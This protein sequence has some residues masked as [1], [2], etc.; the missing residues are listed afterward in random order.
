MSSYIHKYLFKLNIIVLIIVIY[1]RCEK[2]LISVTQ[3]QP[4]P[5]DSENNLFKELKKAEDKMKAYSKFMAEVKQKQKYQEI[6][7]MYNNNN[8]YIHP[9]TSI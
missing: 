9:K 2:L 6:Q 1:F 5:T 7:V 8:N 3:K 4:K